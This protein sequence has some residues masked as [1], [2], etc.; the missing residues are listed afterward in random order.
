MSKLGGSAAAG[1]SKRG[2]GST[3]DNKRSDEQPSRT[4]YAV[5]TTTLGAADVLQVRLVPK[6]KPKANEVLVEV[7]YAGVNRPDIHQREIMLPP[8]IKNTR[9]EYLGPEC[10]GKVSEHGA[11]LSEEDKKSWK[12]GNTVCAITNGGSYA[13]YVAVPVANLL[14][15]PSNA[16]LKQAATFPQ[17]ACTVWSE[18]FMKERL[19]EGLI[20][21]EYPGS[22]LS[23]GETLLIHGGSSGIGTFAIQMAKHQGVTVYVT[24]GSNEKLDACGKLGA[25][26]CIN[27]HKEEFEKVVMK[28]TKGKGVDVILDCLGE[29]YTLENLTC[30]SSGGRLV[31]IGPC[32]NTQG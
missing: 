12:I 13:E 11:G 27:Y 30:L 14:P 31:T 10:S 21:Y 9:S 20:E 24:A 5:V 22:R 2:K 28:E 15:I 6:P 4:M 18:L 25:H 32:C 16:T 1:S 26:G 17:A 23:A 8:D 7:A 3:S 19:S 29:K